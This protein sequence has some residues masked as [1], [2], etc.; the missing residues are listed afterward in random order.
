MPPKPQ[1]KWYSGVCFYLANGFGVGSVERLRVKDVRDVGH[2][3]LKITLNG[4]NGETTIVTLGQ[5]VSG[6][7]QGE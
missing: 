2:K 7:R 3:Q 6:K 1:G 4:A 5:L